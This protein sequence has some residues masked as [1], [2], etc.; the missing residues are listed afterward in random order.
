M[1]LDGC[2]QSDEYITIMKYVSIPPLLNLCLYLIV[3]GGCAVQAVLPITSLQA[4][5]LWLEAAEPMVDDANQIGVD[6]RLGD[7]FAGSRQFFIPERAIMLKRI[8]ADGE[9]TLNPRPGNRPAI[10]F[11]A[12]AQP[13]HTVIAYETIGF[14]LTYKEWEKFIRFTEG[15]GAADILDQHKIRNLPQV[16]FQERY[17]RYAKT[18]LFMSK[19]IEQNND[20]STGLEIEFIVTDVTMVSAAS[21]RITAVLMYQDAPLADAPVTLFTRTPEGEITTTTLA[22]DHQGVISVNT[23]K[24]AYYMLDHVL[25]RPIASGADPNGA[26]WET[27]WASHSFSGPE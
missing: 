12:P 7:M 17:K 24:G 18:S 26:V 5:E 16:D 3:W 6:I 23:Q 22:T 9:T 13:S 11:P 20:T 19:A 2:V 10:S 1:E 14:Y 15:K 4:H 8:T 27:L 21:Q 25:F